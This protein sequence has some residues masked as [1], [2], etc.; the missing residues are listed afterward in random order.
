MA[1]VR[2]AFYYESILIRATGTGLV[3]GVSVGVLVAFIAGI[4][5]SVTS[6]V[7]DDVFMFAFVGPLIGSITGLV[8]G[9]LGGLVLTSLAKRHLG[10]DPN[11]KLFVQR[12]K[13]TCI[14]MAFLLAVI[15]GLYAFLEPVAGVL[16]IFIAWFAVYTATVELS[17]WV[18]QES[19]VN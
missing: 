14:P 3:G 13:Q 8:V 5:E 15:G 18:V 7:L 9:V 6:H 12:A 11:P 10:T 17:K 4:E 19:N 16:F 2:D 1:S